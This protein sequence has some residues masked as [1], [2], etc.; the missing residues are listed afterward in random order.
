MSNLLVRARRRSSTAIRPTSPAGGGRTSSLASASSTSAPAS[1]ASCASSSQASSP[2][3]SPAAP[4][5]RRSSR[6][7]SPSGGASRPYADRTR[8]GSTVR[9]PASGV[10]RVTQVAQRDERRLAQALGL[11]LDAARLV[12]RTAAKPALGE[13][14]ARARHRGVRAAQEGI[15]L[16]AA[17]AHPREP[18]ERHERVPEGRVGEAHRGLDRVRDAEGSEHGLERRAPALHGRDEER[19]GLGRRSGAENAEELVRD[20]LDRAAEPRAGKEAHGAADRRRHRCGLEERALE[21]G[22]RGRG[23]LV[24]PRGQLLDLT[25]RERGEVGRRARERREGRAPGLVGQR[26]VDLG[27]A[28]ERLEQRPLRRGQILEAVREDRLAVPGVEVGAEALARVASHEL[29]VPEPERVELAAIRAVEGA[30]L[31]VEVSRVEQPALDVRERPEQR[32]GEPRE[33][34]RR[35]KRSSVPERGADRTPRE[36]G[37]LGPGRDPPD[38]GTGEGDALEE[39]VE[40]ADRAAEHAAAPL[41][42]VAL[43]ARDVRAVRHDQERLVCQA[44]QIPVEQQ[45]DLA[46][47]GGAGH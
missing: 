31:T 30:E 41:E 44:G 11:L 26:D 32:V 4:K 14:D 16:T 35:R 37:A 1:G 2:S 7:W 3:R 46:R 6:A 33:A 24:R 25:G 15:E 9:T 47:V 42:Q 20:E 8:A 18:Q 39:V 40:G 13:V 38:T 12:H 19:D 43:A 36:Q 23:V 17:A 10:S 45:R 27:P 34:R 28:R 22:E 29:A 21:V 5:L